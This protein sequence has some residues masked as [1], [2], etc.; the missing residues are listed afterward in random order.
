MGLSI[1]MPVPIYLA[2]LRVNPQQ[3]HLFIEMP[4]SIDAGQALSSAGLMKIDTRV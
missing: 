2:M 1:P 3:N 4:A